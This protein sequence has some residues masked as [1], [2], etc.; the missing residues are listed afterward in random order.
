MLRHKARE[1]PKGETY[2]FLYASV[3]KGERNPDIIGI[4]GRSPAAP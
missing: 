4:D 2:F 1:T 3:T